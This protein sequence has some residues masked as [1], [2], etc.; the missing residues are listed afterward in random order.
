MAQIAREALSTEKQKLAAAAEAAET[1]HRKTAAIRRCAE[2][3][4]ELR[5]TIARLET[6]HTERDTE[7]H[8]EAAR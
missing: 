1:L 5:K 6:T 3:L 8:R 7:A 2:A 4:E